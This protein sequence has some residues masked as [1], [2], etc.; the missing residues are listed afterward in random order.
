MT[1]LQQLKDKQSAINRYY[2]QSAPSQ[3]GFTANE[4]DYRKL[5][6]SSVPEIV[7]LAANSL[8]SSVLTDLDFLSANVV[9]AGNLRSVDKRTY[10]NLNERRFVVNDGNTDRILL[11]FSEGGF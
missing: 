5:Y 2:T 6:E 8:P 9:Q 11:G 1:G 10:F 3:E 4:P 7:G